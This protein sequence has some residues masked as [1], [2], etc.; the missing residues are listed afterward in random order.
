MALQKSIAF[1]G[2]NN[3][4]ADERVSNLNA[5][6]N[7]TAEASRRYAYPRM[8]SVHDM[9]PGCGRP[10]P[11]DADATRCAGSARVLLPELVNLSRERLASGGIFL[12]ENGLEMYLWVGAQADP[13]AVQGLFGVPTLQGAPPGSVAP[14]TSGNDLATRLH[15]ICQALSEDAPRWMQ[16][17]VVS[18][19]DAPMES[20]FSW[21]LVEDRASFPSCAYSYAE[22]AQHV[23]QSIMR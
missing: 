12:L 21:F 15:D 4:V 20:R 19:G 17:W 3:V 6:A 10:A 1:R 11:E 23:R 5:L 14:L 18:E 13:A 2:G 7:M 8:F 9:A 22:Y 16:L